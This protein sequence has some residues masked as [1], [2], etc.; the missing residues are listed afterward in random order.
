MFVVLG[1]DH[2]TYNGLDE[3][4]ATTTQVG[5]T[6]PITTDTRW[7]GTTICAAFTPSGTIT[8]EYFL[9]GE[10]DGSTPY[11]YV[12]NAQGSVTV[13][14]SPPGGLVAQYAYSPYGQKIIAPSRK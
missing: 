13:L 8:V 9:Q 1:K 12:R 7:C 6:T 4:V 5:Q 10:V 11:L 3:R 14:A 2:F